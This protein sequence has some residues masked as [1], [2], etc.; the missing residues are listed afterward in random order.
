MDEA[1]ALEPIEQKKV[2]FY[3]DEVTAV[4]LEDGQIY[5]SLR[6]MCQALG[7]DF[8]GQ[9]QRIER[10]EI[11][12][13]GK[14]VC[15][16]QTP[17]GE[18]DVYIL[19]VDLVPLWLS[20]IRVKAVKEH[21]QSK[22]TRFQKEAARVLWAAFERG[23]LTTDGSFNDLLA[24]DTPEAQAYKM[25]QAVLQLAHN[26]LI[27]RGRLD[28]HERQLQMHQHQLATLQATV[29]IL[30]NS[31]RQITEAQ[32]SQL[33][34]AVKAVAMA[35]SKQTRRNEYGGVYGELYR[36]YDITGYK[37]LPVAKFEDAMAWLGEWLAQLHTK[38]GF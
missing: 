9:R 1:Q 19:R 22:L 2:L 20:G 6:H 36:R 30:N 5:A 4:R 17:G 21:L 14:G 24:Q 25:A 29:E 26:Q 3:E 18:Q 10:H 28:E 13:D 15:K 32:A 33:S 7:L 11:L 23:E 12:N 16:L 8:V 31:G 38:N 37:M 27:L 35:L 34:Q